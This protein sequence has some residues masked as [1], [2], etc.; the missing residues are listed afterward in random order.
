MKTEAA[1]AAQIIRKHLKDNGI[2]AKVTSQNYAGGNSINVKTFDLLPATEKLINEYIS[3]FEYGH[4]DGMNDSYNY[5]NVREDIPQVRFVFLN[6]EFSKELRQKAWDWLR[7][8]YDCLTDA[9]SNVDDACHF[10]IKELGIYGDHFLYQELKR[11]AFWRT[12]KP[13]IKV[14]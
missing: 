13:R 12:Q 1:K 4:F 14:A 2:T 5:S 7:G 10:R 3:Q 8:Y 6:N 11:D 9:P